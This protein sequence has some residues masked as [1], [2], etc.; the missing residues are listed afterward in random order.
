MKHS[1]GWGFTQR[2][3]IARRPRHHQRG[4]TVSLR[5]IGAKVLGNDRRGQEPIALLYTNRSSRLIGSTASQT[6]LGTWRRP[7]PDRLRLSARPTCLTVTETNGLSGGERV[8][9]PPDRSLWTARRHQG[10]GTR[11]PERVRWSPG[12][13]NRTRGGR[14]P[15]RGSRVWRYRTRPAS[16]RRCRYDKVKEA[17]EGQRQGKRRRRPFLH[18][19]E[20]S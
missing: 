11:F 8:R 6:V 1:A 7:A 13:H 20:Y 2:L 14:S 18:P 4:A 17:R 15:R 10:E 3:P 19:D 16:L 9:I 12:I 5:Q